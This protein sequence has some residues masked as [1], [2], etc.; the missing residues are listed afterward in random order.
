MRFGGARGG[1]RVRQRLTGA[2]GTLA[3][4][5]HA[6]I[7][8]VDDDATARAAI[9]DVLEEQGYRVF[10]IGSFEEWCAIWRAGTAPDLVILDIMLSERQSGYEILRTL[11]RE[12]THTPVIMV[13]ARNTASDEA[14]ALAH[15]ANGFV[16]KARGE[17]DHPEHGLVATVG[18][19][20]SS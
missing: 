13:S 19:L 15:Q 6:L 7:V 10:A 12:D 16:S 9:I 11:R 8:A 17:F 18:R 2:A 20:L 4:P 1:E 3:A 14:F 5:R